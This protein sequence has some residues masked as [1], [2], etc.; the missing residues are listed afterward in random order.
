MYNGGIFVR[1]WPLATSPQS[2]VLVLVPRLALKIKAPRF[3]PRPRRARV[4][5]DKANNQSVGFMYVSRNRDKDGKRR[6]GLR[7][8]K[9]QTG[10][11]HGWR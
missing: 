5:E 6:S 10:E 3:A 7:E 2:T 11:Q 8:N 9:K 4:K 1:K